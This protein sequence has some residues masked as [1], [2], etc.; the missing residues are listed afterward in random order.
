MWKIKI[1]RKGH[2]ELKFS[3][4]KSFFLLVFQ[5]QVKPDSQIEDTEIP[6][7]QIEDIE[8]PESQIPDAPHQESQAPNAQVNDME[9][10]CLFYFVV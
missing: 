7:S 10:V 2:P 1:L 6:E 4:L 3:L 8:I 9:G 5:Q